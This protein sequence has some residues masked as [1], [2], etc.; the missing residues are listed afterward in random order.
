MSRH[1]HE[2]VERPPQVDDAMI[3]ACLAEARRHRAL[4]FSDAAGW[5]WRVLAG[6]FRRRSSAAET[7]DLARQH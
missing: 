3:A 6:P 4:A 7:L 2:A 5:I 1:T